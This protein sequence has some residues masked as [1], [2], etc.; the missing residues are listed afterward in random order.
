MYTSGRRKFPFLPV[1]LSPLG[2]L[3]LETRMGVSEAWK[4]I[5][6]FL[7]RIYQHSEEVANLYLEH[8]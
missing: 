5:P 6:T 2:R 8:V 4:E 7:G 3:A 1:F